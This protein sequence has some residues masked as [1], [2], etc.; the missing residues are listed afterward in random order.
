MCEKYGIKLWY[1]T[2][3]NYYADKISHLIYYYGFNSVVGWEN[4][5]RSLNI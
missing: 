4:Y 3:P 5:I 1:M 2:S